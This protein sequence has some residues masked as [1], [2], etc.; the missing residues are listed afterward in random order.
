MSNKCQL[1]TIRFY[2]K[3]PKMSIRIIIKSSNFFLNTGTDQFCFRGKK[4][5]IINLFILI[6]S[7]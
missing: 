5:L 4:V 1:E 3:L 7:S 2:L 6:K